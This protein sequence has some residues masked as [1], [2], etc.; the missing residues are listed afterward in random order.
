MRAL[1]RLVL[2]SGVLVVSAPA[3]A[4]S[5]NPGHRPPS[6]HSGSSLRAFNPTDKP[7]GAG[8][9]GFSPTAIGFLLVLAVV[10]GGILTVVFKRMAADMGLPADE[11]QLASVSGAVGVSPR[12]TVYNAV[13]R[14]G[15][16]VTPGRVAMG[17]GISTQE[18]E[19]FLEE[20]AREGRVK[21]GRDK[22]GRILYRIP[23]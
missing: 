7:V 14:A 20:L 16:W 2:L 22:Q 6:S 1:L 11:E 10:T 15:S 8:D 13:S 4:G 9:T 5:G 3:L 23:A 12:E 19:G 21:A 17:A 18:A